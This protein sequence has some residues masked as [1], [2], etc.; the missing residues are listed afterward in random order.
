M[1]GISII[2]DKMNDKL[3]ELVDE[4]EAVQ[5]SSSREVLRH[6]FHAK[7]LALREDFEKRVLNNMS[8]R[9]Q[10]TFREKIEETIEESV[11]IEFEIELQDLVPTGPHGPGCKCPRVVH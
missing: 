4:Y 6:L 7:I 10:L 3:R 11:L 5:T 8:S 1:T 9:K 2:S